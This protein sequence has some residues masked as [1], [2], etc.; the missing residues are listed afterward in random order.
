MLLLSIS[1]NFFYLRVVT[2]CTR[3]QLF[4]IADRSLIDITNKIGPNIEPYE[5]PREIGLFNVTVSRVSTD[6]VFV[7]M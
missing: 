1:Y 2:Y 3:R 6:C 4:A 5:A 7:N